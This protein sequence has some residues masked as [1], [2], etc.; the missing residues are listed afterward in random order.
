MS[1]VRG[2]LTTPMMTRLANSLCVSSQD[3][4]VEILSLL[5]RA[6]KVNKSGTSNGTVNNDVVS[7]WECHI[8]FNNLIM[9]ILKDLNVRKFE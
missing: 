2:R 9:L 8:R 5:F 1:F 4:P 3:S 6:W 7:K